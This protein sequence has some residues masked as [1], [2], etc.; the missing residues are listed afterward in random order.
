ME[1]KKLL[2][3]SKFWV[4]IALVICLVSCIGASLVQTSGGSVEYHDLTLVTS[5]GH[6]MS[7]LL[8]VPDTATKENPAPAIVVS[9]GWYDNR[10]K[11]D[12]NYVEYARRGY[13]VM[14]ISMYGHGDSENVQ[15]N[16]WWYDDTNANGMYDAVKYVASL[17][18]VDSSRIGV[19]GH[20]HGAKASNVAIK[21]DEEGLISA[22]LLVCNEA[23]YTVENTQTVINGRYCINPYD[24]TW[25]NLYGSRDVG[26]V[27]CQYDEFFGSVVQ[28]DGSYSAPKDYINQVTAQ[29]FLH[30][31]VDPTGL[32]QR[33]AYTYYHETIDGEDAFR[34]VYTPALTHPMA[35][36]S[37]DVVSY[38]IEFFEEALGAPTA[39]ASTSQI[40]QGKS[41]FNAVGVVGFFMFA[42]FATLSLLDTKFFGSLKAE[43]TVEPLPG[44]KKAADHLW[45]WLSLAATVAFA[46]IIY[47]VSYD[48]SLEIR[49]KWFEQSATHFILLWATLCGLF[50]LILMLLNYYLHGKRNGLSMKERGVMIR[51][52]KLVKTIILA[53]TVVCATYVLVFLADYFFQTDFRLWAFI[54]IRAFDKA[55]FVQILKYLPFWLIYYVILSVVTNGF[56]YCT[57]GKKDRK[58]WGSTAIQM[59]VVFIGPAIYMIIQYG[60]MYRTG[61]LFNESHGLTG[62]LSGILMW[63]Y[64]VI[65]PITPFI[66]NKIYRKTKNPYIGG[67]IMGTLSC[68]IAVTNS[69]TNFPVNF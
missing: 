46:I 59:L 45:Y 55:K 41:F 31:G 14:A 61:Y 28:E 53:L 13:V 66:C 1:K 16:T 40:W 8:L 44:P 67:I 18:F 26:I 39:I 32:D 27:M 64:L 25:Y 36:F 65:L 38:G 6:E 7:A 54:S 48:W 49:P 4:A 51:P 68:I 2:K 3:S 30:F 22:A 10:E 33:D 56:N 21:L 58:G 43:G 15:Y 35:V 11:Q 52:K 60:C 57:L 19:T 37:S 50:I 42:L 34:V 47:M 63:G 5:S 12:L 9:H 20:S 69:A 17:P 23:Y 24:D 62:S 29:S